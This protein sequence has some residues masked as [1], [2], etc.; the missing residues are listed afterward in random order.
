MSRP[1]KTRHPLASTS[2]VFHYCSYW[3]NWSKVLTS[4]VD[5]NG[6][7]ELN[8]TPINPTL[9]SSWEESIRPVV[10]RNHR[11]SLEEKDKL[12]AELPP[13][14][15]SMMVEHIGVVHTNRLLSTDWLPLLDMPTVRSGRYG[16][17]GIQLDWCRKETT[18]IT[19]AGITLCGMEEHV[20]IWPSGHT[21]IDMKDPKDQIS[22]CGGCREKSFALNP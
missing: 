14:V 11:T 5:S 13:G 17:G 15:W 21:R 22:D 6:I 8:L 9:Q 1:R 4:Y 19:R 20:R 16:G 2:N 7:L 18:H 10:F 3:G 12:L